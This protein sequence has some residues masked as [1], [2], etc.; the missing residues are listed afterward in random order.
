MQKSHL[1][2]TGSRT[3]VNGLAKELGLKTTVPYRA[4]FEGKQ[5]G[6]WTQVYGDNQLSFCQHKR[7][8]THSSGNATSKIIFTV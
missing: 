6:R 1:P 2:I 4:R 8:F 7:S 3:L 5:V